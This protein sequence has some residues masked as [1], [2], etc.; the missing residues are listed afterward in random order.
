MFSSST[1]QSISYRPFP[2]GKLVVTDG[3]PV[4]KLAAGSNVKPRKAPNQPSR[5]RHTWI[6]SWKMGI[7]R[8]LDAVEVP[9]RTSVHKRYR[10]SPVI[11]AKVLFSIAPIQ[12]C[13]V[14][15]FQSFWVLCNA[16]VC[17][18]RFSRGICI[19][20]PVQLCWSFTH[21]SFNFISFPILYNLMEGNGIFCIKKTVENDGDYRIE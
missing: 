12:W 8:A 9:Y 16:F 4:I 10:K 18:A 11:W 6:H 14:E 3:L 21:C 15:S 13:I 5:C 7:R 2:H 20:D 17:C 1:L 19:I